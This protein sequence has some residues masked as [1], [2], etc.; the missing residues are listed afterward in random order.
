M[1]GL[2]SMVER[3]LDLGGVFVFALSGAY[4]AA[5]K[6]FDV[7]GIL[8]LAMATGLGGGLLRDVLL[9]DV[10]P[11]AV[12][13]QLY[14]AAPIV[15]GLIVFV[16][17]DAVEK[18]WRPVH[19]FDAVGLGLFSVVGT[20]KSL[21]YGVGVAPSVMLGVTTAVGGGILRDV[22]AREVPSVFRADSALYAVPAALGSVATAVLWSQD[23]LGAVTALVVVGSVVAIRVLAMSQGWRAPIA[24]GRPGRG[25]RPA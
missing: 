14:L 23:W 24:R 15:A 7:V 12:R 8:V 3:A 5:R 17:Q 22:L 20:A 13:D 25:P 16:G 4:L 2:D 11:V 18:V 21:D 19:V 1:T 9:G 6:G 10:P